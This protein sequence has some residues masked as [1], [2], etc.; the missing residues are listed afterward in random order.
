MQWT[1]CPGIQQV[2][3]EQLLR[4]GENSTYS[5]SLWTKSFVVSPGRFRDQFS[6]EFSWEAQSNAGGELRTQDFFLAQWDGKAREI[7][8]DSRKYKERIRGLLEDRRPAR[9]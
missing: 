6:E 4:T 7:S 9:H 1:C 8:G 2:I 5:Q 3:H